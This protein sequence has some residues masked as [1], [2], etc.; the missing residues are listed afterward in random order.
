MQRPGPEVEVFGNPSAGSKVVACR[1]QLAIVKRRLA[2]M[3]PDSEGQESHR[4]E[5]EQLHLTIAEL[6]Q[7]LAYL[8]AATPEATVAEPEAKLRNDLKKLPA[9]ATKKETK[10][11]QLG[12]TDRRHPLAPGASSVE[13]AKRHPDQF[14]MIVS[15]M[16]VQLE[17]FVDIDPSPTGGNKATSSGNVEY[18]T[19]LEAARGLQQVVRTNGSSKLHYGDLHDVVRNCGLVLQ[20]TPPVAIAEQIRKLL[21][22]IA[23][24]MAFLSEDTADMEQPAP[25]SENPAKGTGYAAGKH[26]HGDVT[27]AP[28][29]IV[30]LI[31]KYFG[32]EAD[33]IPEIPLWFAGNHSAKECEMMLFDKTNGTFLI[34]DSETKADT[35]NLTLRHTDLIFHFRIN[36]NVDGDYFIS[37]KDTFPT[38]WELVRHHSTK[39]DI[40]G[41]TIELLF[42]VFSYASNPWYHGRISKEQAENLLINSE[43]GFYLVRRSTS[44]VGGFTLTLRMASSIHHYRIIPDGGRT[45]GLNKEV[46]FKSLEK[47]IKFY[48]KKEQGASSIPKLVRSFRRESSHSIDLTDGQSYIYVNLN[49]KAQPVQANPALAIGSGF[50]KS[51]FYQRRYMKTLE[52]RRVSGQVAC[53]EDRQPVDSSRNSTVRPPPPS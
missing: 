12:D 21:V 26:N 35:L 39:Q 42:P 28:T 13:A 11:V 46:R 43:S 16:S 8:E 4:Q 19:I 10:Y 31:R 33:F 23:R 50:G 18:D 29:V 25:D 32:P 17:R 37:E 30:A 2:L 3:P 5:R 47:M 48:A 1:E 14:S 7:D 22:I 9:M 52:L 15:E 24:P 40:G 44:E 41:Y 34:R 49:A 27:H 36:R 20:R 53:L 38:L 45:F 51:G 6:A